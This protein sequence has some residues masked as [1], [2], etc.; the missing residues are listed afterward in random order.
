VKWNSA[1]VED[2]LLHAHDQVGS[3]LESPAPELAAYEPAAPEPEATA[4]SHPAATPELNATAASDLQSPQGS[5]LDAT[6]ALMGADQK[7]MSVTATVRRSGDSGGGDTIGPYQLLESIGEGGMGTVFVAKQSKPIK[8]TVAIKL[9]KAGMDTKQVLARFEAERQTLALMDHPNI[10]RVVDAGMTDQGRPFFAME[11]VKGVPLTEYC[12]KARLSVRE[13][14]ELFIPI[15][16]AV[17][18]AH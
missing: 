9:V 7:G 13:R 6:S 5:H 3:L 14:L 12:D 2:R 18:H 1:R 8:R 4:A 15:C 11:Y 10:A 16:Q 17:Q